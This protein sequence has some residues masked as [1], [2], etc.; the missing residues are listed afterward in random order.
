M[1]KAEEMN[2]LRGLD[3][4]ALKQ[5]VD[6]LERGLMNLRFRGGSTGQLESP[7]EL[8]NLRRRIARA[9][10]IIREKADS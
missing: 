9:N 5:R 2:E 7:A 3:I 6:E 1:K 10:T 8:K 4:G